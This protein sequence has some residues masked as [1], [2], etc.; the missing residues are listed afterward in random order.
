MT[1]V[2]TAIPL[3]LL[4]TLGYAAVCAANP[5]A[6]CRR[7]GGMGHALTTDRKGR[8]RR[9]K[10]CRRCKATG[11]RIRTGRRLFHR[12]ARIHRDGTR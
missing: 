8:P 6:A 5:F 1:L 10:D 11:R 2:A 3:A 12:A 9:G 7:C 4:V